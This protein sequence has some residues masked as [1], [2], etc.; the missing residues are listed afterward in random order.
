MR[1]D[2]RR[3][4]AVVLVPVAL[5][6]GLATQPWA[7]GETSDVLSHGITSVTGSEAAPGV[8]GL[9]LVAVAALLGLMTGG[10]VIKAISAG[11]LVLAS[12]GAL[13]LVGLVVASPAQSVAAQVARELARTTSPEATGATTALGWLGFVAALLLTAGAIAAVTSSRTWAGLSGRYERAGRAEA[14]PRGQVRTAWDEMTDGGDPTVR[15]GP[16]RT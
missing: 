7:T 3:A 16:E 12:L 10:R 5:L 15:D 13:V 14:G 8:I 2:K 11:V 9:G 4:A 6:L 1:L